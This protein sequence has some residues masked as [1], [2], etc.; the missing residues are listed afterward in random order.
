[1][2]NSEKGLAK[3]KVS[4]GEQVVFTNDDGYWE[5]PLIVENAI[6][7]IK[8][9][10]Y[11]TGLS[12]YHLPQYYY[13]HYPEGSPTLNIPGIPPSGP[14]PSYI[15]FP[16]YKQDEPDKFSM[17]LFADTQARGIKEV[18]YISHDIIEECIGSE[19]AF[20]ITLGDIVAD[21]PALFK[22]I[23]EST[24][25]IGIP[26]FYVFGNHDHNRDLT[27]D[28]QRDDTFKRFFGPSTYAFEYAQV[29]FIVIRDIHYEPNG[30]Y[31]SSYTEQQLSFVS[32]YLK[33][34]PIDKRVVILQH[35]PITR[36]IGR[37]SL[38]RLIEHRPYTLSFSGH[39][40]TLN[41][42][43]LNQE[44]GWNGD[45][46]HHH[47]INATVSGSWWVGL[48]DETGIPHATMNDGA[49]NGY[50]IVNFD[51]SD[52]SIRFKAARRPA[53]Y[54]MN[55]HLQDDILADSLLNTQ[56]LVNVFAGSERSIVKMRISGFSEWIPMEYAPQVDP[57]NQW[58]HSLSPFLDLKL[59]NGKNTEEALGWKMDPARRSTHIWAAKMPSNLLPGTYHL[60]VH[61]KDMFGQEDIGKRVFRIR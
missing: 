30:K 4:N 50:S 51:K 59:S 22:E 32:N 47:F 7:V 38:F 37:E 43:F 25:Q 49:P 12:E 10:G 45:S 20:G 15:N 27:N 52:Y 29:S 58:M 26:W 16:L 61:S 2:D 40:H 33:G 36:T 17:L 8:P 31:V 42:V 23:S 55:I 9:S 56:V 6:F 57:L 3:I 5:L 18:N 46:P 53:N 39:T 1:M 19:A 35:A 44:N 60:E 54:Q 48:K 41:H 34:L 11:K 24:A 13:L 21:D 14:L 28:Q